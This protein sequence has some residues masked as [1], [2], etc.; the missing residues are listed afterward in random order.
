M[1]SPCMRHDFVFVYQSSY[2]ALF[3]TACTRRQLLCRRADQP[4]V[5]TWPPTPHNA[6]CI[7]FEFN[8]VG[9]GFPQLQAASAGVRPRNDRG[10]SCAGAH[11]GAC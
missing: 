1:C 2:N 4:W 9:I 7:A 6:D 8:S 5:L 10:W 3:I 11:P